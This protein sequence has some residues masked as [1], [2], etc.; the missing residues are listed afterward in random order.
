MTVDWIFKGYLLIIKKDFLHYAAIKSCHMPIRI[1]KDQPDH[2]RNRNNDPGRDP[3]QPKQKSRFSIG[4]IL[5]AIYAIIKKPKW[6]I[7]ILIILG[8]YFLFKPSFSSLSEGGGAYDYLAD[9]EQFSFG[10]ELNEEKYDLASVFEPLAVGS[11]SLPAQASLESYAPR[12][13]HQGRQGSCSGW[14]GAYAGRTISFAQATGRRPDQIA[15]SPSFLYNQIAL[16]RCQGAYLQEAMEAMKK[17]GSLPFSQFGYT[18]Q[19]CQN[20]PDYSDRSAASPFRIKGYNRLTQGAGNY[21][22]D[23]YGIKQHLAQGAPVL[24]GMMVGQS[25]QRDMMGRKLWRPTRNDYAGMNLGGHAMCLVGYDD[26]VGGGAFRVMNSWG[27]EWGDNGFAWIG[28]DDFNKFTKEAY[29]FFPE[30]KAKKFDEDRLEVKFALV[31][32]DNQRIIPLRQADEIVFKTASAMPI[33]TKFKLAVTNSVECYTYVFGMETD[34]SSY[35][36]FPYTQKHSPYCGIT[37]TR[38]FPK[39]YSMT[40]DEIGRTDYMAIIVSKKPLDYQMINSRMNRSNERS[41]MLRMVN[42]IIDDF[43]PECDFDV[44]GSVYFNCN[45]SERS[46]IGMIIEVEKR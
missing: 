1:E 33:G 19:T 45:T 21:A 26:N 31:N 42:S 20:L 8:L 24:I 22:P 38:L 46:A 30:G 2:Q 4:V 25:F 35:V 29:G 43:V 32:N 39:D 41:Y 34:G 9:N 15:F 3:A 5:L 27:K 23:F 18:D 14:A 44:D 13:L 11:T 36:L 28:Y 16:P 40:P 17:V 7:P 10:A 37:G 12:I 6:F